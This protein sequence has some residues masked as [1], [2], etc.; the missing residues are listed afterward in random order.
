MTDVLRWSAGEAATAIRTGQ[1][2]VQE[3]TQAHIARMKALDPALNVITHEVDDALDLAR[4]MDA[5]GI[6]ETAGPLWGVPVTVKVNVDMAGYPTDNGIPAFKDTNGAEDSAV[7]RSLKDSGAVIIG[8]TNAPEFSMR[9]LTSNPLHGQSMNPWHEDITPGG[10]S[11]G[12]AAAVATGIGAIAHGND[13]GGS[14]RF[15][16]YCCGVATIRPSFGRVAGPIGRFLCR[17]TL[18]ENKRRTWVT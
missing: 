10:S 3:L 2:S 4:A 11:G 16:A 14:L 17:T 13:L 1:I 5:Q 8:R 6:P 15:P 18:T 9:W 12:A 7:V